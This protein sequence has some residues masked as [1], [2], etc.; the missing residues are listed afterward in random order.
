MSKFGTDLILVLIGSTPTTF[1]LAF[2]AI[3]TKGLRRATHA[4]LY[5]TVI[6]SWLEL[7]S[8]FLSQ[9]TLREFVYG[10]SPLPPATTDLGIQV[11]TIIDIAMNVADI[12]LQLIEDLPDPVKE[13]WRNA[14]KQ[15]LTSPAALQ[16]KSENASWYPEVAMGFVPKRVFLFRWRSK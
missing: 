8:K 15:V 16:Y 12:T 10:S 11:R 5:Q 2:Q 4:Q 7:D 13:T 14:A 6:A 9:P 3:Q 1:A